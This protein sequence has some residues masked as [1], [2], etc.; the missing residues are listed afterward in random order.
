ML[1]SDHL[2]HTIEEN[3]LMGNFRKEGNETPE[4]EWLLYKRAYRFV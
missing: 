3:C 2:S 4:M 1:F